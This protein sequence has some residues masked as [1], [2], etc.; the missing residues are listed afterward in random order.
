M[1]VTRN[2]TLPRK[3]GNL[4]LFKTLVKSSQHPSKIIYP[5]SI[6]LKSNLIFFKVKLRKEEKRL[7]YLSNN[8]TY[9]QRKRKS[10]QHF[11]RN[12]HWSIVPT[13]NSYRET[14]K[15]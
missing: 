10:F 4:N 7:E 9:L 14:I 12:I 15:T 2:Q 11:H 8:K 13:K 3:V 1:K 6:F 5:K